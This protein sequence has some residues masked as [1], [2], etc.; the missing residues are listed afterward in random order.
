MPDSNALSQH[1]S[2]MTYATLPV[3]ND[4][5]VSKRLIVCLLAALRANGMKITIYIIPIIYY[6]LNKHLFILLF[7]ILK[8]FI[9]SFGVHVPLKT[10]DRQT[11]EFYTKMGFMELSQ[12]SNPIPD[13]LYLG[14]VF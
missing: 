8:Y 2:V 4:P 1:K 12:G 5:S 13:F 11:I 14:R 9:G 3:N 7:I 10:K 6:Y